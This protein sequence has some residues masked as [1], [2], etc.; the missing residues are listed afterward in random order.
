[1]AVIVSMTPEF[2]SNPRVQVT[3]PRSGWGEGDSL[4]FHLGP[5]RDFN[6]PLPTSL[7]SPLT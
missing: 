3:Y 4:S 7:P 2:L 6:F 5:W 1:M